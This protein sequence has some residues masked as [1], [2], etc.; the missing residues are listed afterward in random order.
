MMSRPGVVRLDQIDQCTPRHN[1]LNL[2]QKA[3]A[4][5]ALFGRGL[6]KI[7][8]GEALREAVTERLSAHEASPHLQLQPHSH[9]GWRGFPGSP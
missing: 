8:V 5:N 9:A 1:R 4:P 3:L 7:T 2:S 6:L